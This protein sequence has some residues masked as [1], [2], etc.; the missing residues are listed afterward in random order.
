MPSFPPELYR[1][2][3]EWVT[4]R[5]DL[6][7]LSI[8]SRL[9]SVEAQRV[10]YSVVDLAQNTRAPVLWADTILQQPQK[11]LIVRALTLRFDLSFLIVP[12]LLL[13]ALKSIAQALKALRRLEKLV[14]VGHPLAMMHP[15]HTW[16]L[17]GCPPGLR[18]FH[19]SVFP[20]WAV[21]PFL[22]RHP[23]IREW[24]QTGM[25]PR[26]DMT[27]TVLPQLTVLDA[28]VSTLVSFKT[29]RPLTRVHLTIDDAGRE[30]ERDAILALS[31]FGTSLTTL[32][33]ED[34]STRNNLKLPDFFCQLAKAVPNL[35][36]LFYTRTS[37]LSLQDLLSPN[38]IDNLSKF[39]ALETLV[40]RLRRQ[41]LLLDNHHF[42]EIAN[43]AFERCHSLNCVALKDEVNYSFCKRTGSSLSRDG[44]A[45]LFSDFLDSD[46]PP[47]YNPNMSQYRTS[48][49]YI[50]S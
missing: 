11:A 21:I 46:S 10:L 25:Y 43:C 39:E 15:I 34:S 37:P 7:S 22:S 12:D 13:T 19:N 2:I 8:T 29:T 3:I 42:R 28:H 32:T 27:D 24:K 20:A 9:C 17:D 48:S 38:S 1:N 47:S 4:D 41:K 26:D 23:Q 36:S 30:T 16:I 5:R 6:C 33:I 44:I 50:A 14:I 31:N 45:S 18:I 40:L 49:P 35:K